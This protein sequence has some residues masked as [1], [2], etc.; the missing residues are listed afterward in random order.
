MIRI[1]ELLRLTWF[2]KLPERLTFS[3]LLTVMAPNL[4]SSRTALIAEAANK[5]KIVTDVPM[6]EIKEKEVLVEVK[7]V[8]LNPSDWKLLED[9]TCT[10]GAIVG[11][12]F[13]GIVVGVGAAVSSCSKGLQ[14]G[15][16]VFGCVF[17]S[18]PAHPDGG[19]FAEYIAAPADLCFKMPQ[20]MRFES[21]AS[22]G[23]GLMTAGLVLKSLGLSDLRP[24]ASQSA[25]KSLALVYGASTATGT[26]AI[27]LLKHI[28]C[29]VI[30]VC[31][32]RNFD[33]VIDRGAV[34]AFDY[35]S[36]SCVQ[37]IRNFSGGRVRYAVDCIATSKS[38]TICYGSI[39][40]DGGRYCALESIPDR[41]QHRRANVIPDWILGWTMFGEAVSLAGAYS[42][43]ARP[44][45]RVFAAAWATYCSELLVR[46]Q[47]GSHPVNVRKGLS[48][49]IHDIQ[50]LRRKQISG[51][52]LVYV[53][54]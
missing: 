43:E 5:I 27:Q 28:G 23:L 12:D 2:A 40:G 50:L 25:E 35:S 47:L 1:E 22:M 48:N 39:G 44:E 8:A 15:D 31:S 19:A 42:R 13:S 32:P 17:G 49:V 36:P 26:L 46:G 10:P 33:L 14:I 34:V 3:V 52:K 24:I 38:T 4:R 16:H 41:L 37:D 30:A 9:A 20:A 53:M 54:A 21:A 51:R 6:P 11:S 18:N 7:A 45:D 29:D